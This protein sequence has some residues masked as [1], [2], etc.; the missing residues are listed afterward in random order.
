[1]NVGEGEVIVAPD[2]FKGI[3][4]YWGRLQRRYGI[5]T[6]GAAPALPNGSAIQWDIKRRCCCQA[7]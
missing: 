4:H 6:H 2:P 1:M 7:H 5:F 3:N